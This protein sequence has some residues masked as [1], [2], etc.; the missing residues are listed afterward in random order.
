[1][2]IGLTPAHGARQLDG[3]RV[4]QEFLGQRGFTGVGVRNDGERA[5][6]LDFGLQ[7]LR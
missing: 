6:A 1:V 4:Q 7:R 3:A 5:T 2:A